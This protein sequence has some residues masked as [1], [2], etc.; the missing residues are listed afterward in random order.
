LIPQRFELLDV[1]L[2]LGAPDFTAGVKLRFAA[3]SSNL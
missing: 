2:R 1:Y 3:S